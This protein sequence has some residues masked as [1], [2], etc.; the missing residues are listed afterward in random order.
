MN[1]SSL[2]KLNAYLPI[3]TSFPITTSA[4][5]VHSLN[6]PSAITMLS[7]IVT[8]VISVYENAYLPISVSA[9]N[10]GSSVIDVSKYAYSPIV[11]RLPSVTFTKLSLEANAYSPNVV[12]LSNT[13]EVIFLLF[14]NAP[15]ATVVTALP[16]ILALVNS[17]STIG[18]TATNCVPSTEII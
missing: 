4:R 18:D 9:V 1:D 14:E 13:I 10:A 2:F 8:D 6:T 17:P 12:T 3:V 11:S 16:P 7:G 5:L 15:L